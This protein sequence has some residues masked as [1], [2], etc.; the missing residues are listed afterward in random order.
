MSGGAISDQKIEV[1]PANDADMPAIAAI[2][3]EV[4]LGQRDRQDVA[5]R[6]VTARYNFRAGEH[7]AYYYFVITVDDEVAG[8]I[9]WE[10]YGGFLRANPA[11]ELEQLGVARKF[12]GRGLGTRLTQ[13]TLETM[14][15]TICTINDKIEGEIN[16]FVWVYA[17]NAPARA[18]YEKDFGKKVMGERTIFGTRQEVMYLTSRPWRRAAE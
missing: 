11:V 6:W 13:E 17:H 1:R 5:L 10:I 8:Y 9:G 14:V 3:A 16:F 15:D 12:K 18:V 2:N 7:Q 4:F